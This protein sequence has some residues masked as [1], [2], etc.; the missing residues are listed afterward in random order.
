MKNYI[1][2][3]TALFTLGLA[4]PQVRANNILFSFTPTTD[5]T[6]NP[7]SGNL[8]TNTVTY[9]DG[10]TGDNGGGADLATAYGFDCGSSANNAS[11]AAVCASGTNY[12]NNYNT[13]NDK[14]NLYGFTGGGLGL[15]NNNTS[16]YVDEIPNVG[17]VQVDFSSVIT[18][19]KAAGDTINDVV[20]TV[21]NVNQGWNA[22]GS[23]TLGTL[24]PSGTGTYYTQ[25]G[26]GAPGGSGLGTIN[27]V[28]TISGTQ[29]ATLESEEY[30]G[31]SGAANCDVE[32]TSIEVQYTAGTQGG[33]APEPSTVV[34]M[35]F[36]LLGLGVAGKKLQRRA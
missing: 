6:S 36:A 3:A 10:G 34:L 24:D 8:G 26:L 15:A 17:F 27:N 4:A 30:L 19:L 23:N 28:L 35:G 2:A 9:K 33:S 13:T 25:N 1:Y 32:L 18:A 20:V 12:Q 31:I 16:G 21:S 5:T 7:T 14:S 29:L 22:W 11:G